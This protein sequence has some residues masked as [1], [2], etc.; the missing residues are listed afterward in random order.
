MPNHELLTRISAA[1][2][3]RYRFEREIGTGGMATVYLATDLKHDRAVALKVLHPELGAVLGSDRFLQEIRIAA[4][5]DHPHI[6]TLID[7]GAADGLLYYVLPYVRGESLRETLVREGRLGVERALSITRQV[8]AAL[9]YAH[10]QGVVHRDIKP[11]NILLQEG[12]AMLADF[13][14]ALAVR[15]AGGTRLTQSGVSLG[16]PQYMSPEQATG[17]PQIDARSDEYSLAAV[18]YEMLAGSPPHAGATAQAL[19]AKVL[20]ERPAKL[21]V[22]RKDVPVEVEQAVAR[23]LAKLPADRFVDVPSFVSALGAGTPGAAGSHR[24]RR[25]AV[26]VAGI[27]AGLAGLFLLYRPQRPAIARMFDRTQVTF[28]GR[29]ADPILSPDGTQLAYSYRECA[30]DGGCRHRIIMHDMVTNVER[31]V[32]DMGSAWVQLDRWSQSGS[33]L[34]L[35][36]NPPGR[37]LG[38]YA[39]SRLGGPLLWMGLGA[40]DF[41]PGGDTVLVAS[42][43]GATHP[44]WLRAIPLPATQ[45][46]D[47][48]ALVPPRGAEALPALRVSPDGRWMAITYLSNHTSRLTLALY[49]RAARLVDSVEVPGSNGPLRWL[50]NGGALLEPI[51]VAQGAALWRVRV[52]QGHFGIQD[53]VVLG[54][55]DTAPEYDVTAD[56]QSL[57][58]TSLH[59]GEHVLWTLERS[60]PG[61]PL[62][63]LRRVFSSTLP[64]GGYI[65]KDGQT[66][67]YA[68]RQAVG[69][70]PVFEVYAGA[71]DGGAGRAVTPPLVNVAY[72]N[73]T[74]DDRRLVVVN[75]SAE[76]RG[77]L[78]AYDVA[79]GHATPMG[80]LPSAH[81]NVWEAGPDGLVGVSAT[82]DTLFVLDGAGALRRRISLPDSIGNVA[83]PLVSSPTAR[84]MAF[85]TYPPSESGDDG[86]LELRLYRVSL[87]TGQITLVAQLRGLDM[88]PTLGWTSDGWIHVALQTA[89]DQEGSLY[90]VRASGGVPE[91]E[92]ALPFAPDRCQ[93]FMSSDG[94]RWVGDVVHTTR[95]V[96]LIRNFVQAPQ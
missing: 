54:P 51:A 93:C 24:R 34:L 41:V 35:G 64:I 30:D 8:A 48:I 72:W 94:R 92:S 71:F 90:R 80:E 58:Y 77:R 14:I 66:I 89:S 9:D 16:T 53:T 57:V 67:F 19:L 76:G 10:R 95:D 60:V 21:R 84:D 75:P 4:R 29:A 2:A 83:T 43:F 86:N 32:V 69:D 70:R 3:D 12:E 17:D 88:R 55:S 15:E 52:D 56:G 44:L 25:A 40:G 45:A 23:A 6:L 26:A 81:D 7:S 79:S 50:G 5:L 87:T 28:S 11:E 63:P 96:Y 39:V 31:P 59:S 18:L 20:T 37:P 68:V 61:G 62:R 82:N 13:G 78:T 36:A 22:V 1:L 47:S 74:L 85:V 38:G 91:R 27:A 65:S 73:P 49:D 33:W 46:V 42:E